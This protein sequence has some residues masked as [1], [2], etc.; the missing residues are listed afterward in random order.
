[1]AWEG[2]S[3]AQLVDAVFNYTRDS[4]AAFRDAGVL[5]DMVQIGNEIPGGMLWPDGKAPNNW[6]HFADLLKAG[7]AGVEAGKGNQPRPRIMI[8]IDKGGDQVAHQEFFRQ[9]Q[10]L[11]HQLRCHRSILLSVVARKPERPARESD[12]HGQRLSEGHHRGRDRL[13]LE[14]RPSTAT[15]RRRSPKLRK[16]KSSFSRN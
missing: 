4:I 10:Y 11:P 6:D 12:F 15:N 7:I 14:A 3:H 13:Q 2:F 5:P 9:A 1:M 16:A 8:H